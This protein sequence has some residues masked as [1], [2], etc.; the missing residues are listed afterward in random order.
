[1]DKNRTSPIRICGLIAATLIALSSQGCDDRKLTRF[2]E[3]ETNIGL[4]KVTIRP[5]SPYVNHSSTG[6]G[7]SK[8]HEMTCAEIRIVL[9]GRELIVNNRTYGE[10]PPR[11]TILVEYGKVFI[12]GYAGQ[13]KQ[14][15]AKKDSGL[16]KN[17]QPESVTKLGGYSLTVRPGNLL[18]TRF[19][20]D[21]AH[22][23]RLGDRRFT[24]KNDEFL[25]DDVSY[26]KLY[27]GDS[28][29]VVDGKV[30]I[31]G[32]ERPPDAAVRK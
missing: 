32:R 15:V 22:V 8:V 2:G 6:S 23:L 7:A 30:F 1:M 26:G 14:Y 5:G 28:I 31:G 11:S 4:H 16:D 3:T 25:I 9:R 19:L 20:V 18:K 10:I 12:D 27:P 29:S 24:V 13:G 21:G 17:E